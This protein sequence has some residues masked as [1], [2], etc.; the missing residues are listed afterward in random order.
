L[1]ERLY[2]D[3]GDNIEGRRITSLVI[4]AVKN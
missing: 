4:M 2:R 1:E 3:G